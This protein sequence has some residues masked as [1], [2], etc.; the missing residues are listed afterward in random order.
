MMTPANTKYNDH[1]KENRLSYLASIPI[2]SFHDEIDIDDDQENNNL[3]QKQSTKL[4]PGHNVRFNLSSSLSTTTTTKK[5]TSVVA[6]TKPVSKQQLLAADFLQNFPLLRA[7]V[8]E[9]LTLQDHQGD[10][11]IPMRRIIFDERPRSAGQQGLRKLKQNPIRPKSAANTRSVR[12]KS[13]IVARN[14]NNT[15]RLYPPPLETRQM[16]VTKTEVRNLVDR[17]SKPKF[18]KRYEREVAIAEQTTISEEPII[19]PRSSSKPTSTAV[20]FYFSYLSSF[21]FSL[22]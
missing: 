17:L 14:I 16:L 6:Q 22:H 4:K 13:V 5:P 10:I 21:Y 7:L 3:Q 18:N 8:E 19:T 1:A 2:A 15:R 20:C 9:A 12:P 11:S